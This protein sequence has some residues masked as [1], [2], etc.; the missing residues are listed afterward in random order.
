MKKHRGLI[1]FLSVIVLIGLSVAFIMTHHMLFPQINDGF[2]ISAHTSHQPEMIAHRG[3]SGLERENTCAAF[4]AAGN[5][6]YYGIETDIHI[7]RDGRFIVYHD[8]NTL[9]LTGVDSVVQ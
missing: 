5:R 8:D 6:S 4:I 2:S 3:L 1:I 7:T 9:R